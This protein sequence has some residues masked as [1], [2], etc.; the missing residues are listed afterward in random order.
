MWRTS[1]STAIFYNSGEYRI[2]LGTFVVCVAIPVLDVNTGF[3]AEII[4]SNS[5][6]QAHAA[7]C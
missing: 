4:S 3:N 5:N 2:I 7:A 1:V 6:F